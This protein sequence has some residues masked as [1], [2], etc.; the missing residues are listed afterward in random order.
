MKSCSIQTGLK[1]SILFEQQYSKAY[2]KKVATFEGVSSVT[3]PAVDIIIVGD[4]TGC[5][6][7]RILKYL[8]ADKM[9]MRL[10]K[11]FKLRICVESGPI[12]NNSQKFTLTE[13]IFLVWIACN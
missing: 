6:S 1:K 3:S 8:T 7:L 4:I 9:K 13:I 12:Y 10:Q 5:Y 11:L 2:I